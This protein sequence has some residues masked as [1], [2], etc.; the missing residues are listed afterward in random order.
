MGLGIL[1]GRQTWK[2][3]DKV[4]AQM[5]QGGGGKKFQGGQF[6][7]PMATALLLPALLHLF[8]ISNSE[9]FVMGAQKYFYPR[10]QGTLA[11]PLYVTV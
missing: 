8:C 7:A 4:S 2:S 5:A 1:I 9:V 3:G 10:A 6:P 11:M